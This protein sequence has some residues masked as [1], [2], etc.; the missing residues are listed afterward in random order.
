VSFPPGALPAGVRPPV[1]AIREAEAGVLNGTV[2]LPLDVSG[3]LRHALAAAQAG[4][5]GERARSWATALEE[6]VAVVRAYFQLLEAE[7]LKEVTE[8]TMAAERRQ[9]AS[10]EARY[11]AGRL[12][13]NDLL[14]VQVTLLSGEQRLVQRALAIAEARWALNQAVGLPVDAPTAVAN[15]TR[16]PAVPPVDEALREAYARN[17]VLAGLREEQ[18][19]LEETA[20]ALVRSRLPRVAGGGAIDYASSDIVQPQDVGSGFVGFSLDLGTDTR[21][22]ADIAEARIAAERNRITVEREMRALEAAVR[23]VREAAEERLAALTASGAAVGQA[24]ENLRI[25]EQQFD[26]GRAASDDVLAALA[27]LARERATLATALYQAHTR[28]AEL[29]QL[30]GLPVDPAACE[31]P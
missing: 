16:A 19:R 1:V 3:E 2:T 11:T 23:T 5:R 30:M 7:R 12:T 4:Y 21:R 6:Q 22:E 8:Q 27:L 15:V 29:R 13:K 24:E 14:V 26:M 9:L 20:R 17:P 18:Q 31:G 25:R 28:A 10:A